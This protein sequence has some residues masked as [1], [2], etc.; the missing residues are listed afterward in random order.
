MTRPRNR[1]ATRA[2]L[3]KAAKTTLA[4]QGF[5]VFGI[6]AV[7]RQAGCDK[8]LIY[9]YFDGLEGLL[10]AI[11]QDVAQWIGAATDNGTSSQDETYTEKMI[12][13]ADVYLLALRA[14]PLMQKILLWELSA[15]AEQVKPLAEARGK[16]M[17][18]WMK[19]AR[20]DAIPPP[21]ADYALINASVVAIIHQMVLSSSVSGGFS[22][23]PLQSEADWQRLRDGL[24]AFLSRLYAVP[25]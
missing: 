11:G 2:A 20:G 12:R 19:R 17:F 7:A 8:Q 14:S 16:A 23:L 24:K 15:P 18:L 9:R 25:A 22:G 4:E 1:E 13:F 21:G 3:L 10:E 6:N 5:Q